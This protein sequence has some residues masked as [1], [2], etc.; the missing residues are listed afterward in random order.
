MWYPTKKKIQLLEPSIQTSSGTPYAASALVLTVTTRRL[1]HPQPDQ[2]SA[3]SQKD[4]STK[5]DSRLHDPPDPRLGSCHPKTTCLM[6]WRRHVLEWPVGQQTYRI[7][8]TLC[9]SCTIG[10]HTP[11]LRGRKPS[12]HLLVGVSPGD[13]QVHFWL[14]CGL[15]CHKGLRLILPTQTIMTRLCY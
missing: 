3:I 5:W 10:Y 12:S 7:D 2:Q 6:Y 11:A 1:L 13:C 15:Q 14:F 4:S 9:F 8:P